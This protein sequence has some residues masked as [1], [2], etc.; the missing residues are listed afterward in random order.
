MSPTI[1]PSSSIPNTQP[2]SSQYAVDSDTNQVDID[3][4]KESED[5]SSHIS[6]LEHAP[7]R[8][9]LF[10]LFCTLLLSIGSHYSAHVLSS[11][12]S[13]LKEELN[14]SNAQYG[15]LQSGVSLVNTIIPVLGGRIIDIFGV[16]T[17]SLLS[18]F[19]ITF[20][21]LFVAMSAS[22]SSFPLMVLGR[23]LYGLGSGTIVTV[24]H[25]ILAHW[26]RGKWLSITIG[27]QIAVARLSSFLSIA[28][29]VP[30]KNVSGW[31][32]TPFYL[33]FLLCAFS[34]AI[35]VFYVFGM[36]RYH[37]E[38][39]GGRSD[40]VTEEEYKRLRRK[41]KF[42]IGDV[43]EFT[44]M[45]WVIAYLSFLMGGSWTVFLHIAPELMKLH[46]NQTE[47]LAAYNASVGQFLPIVVSP[48][49]GY[50]L[51]RHGH[52]PLI[53]F[54]ATTSLL[55]SFVLLGFAPLT[56]I[57]GLLLFSIS[58]TFGPVSMV[59][60]IPLIIKLSSVGTALGI[61]KSASNIATTMMDPLVGF[62]QDETK[63]YT[64]P[65]TLLTV[66]AVLAVTLSL[67]LIYIDKSHNKGLLSANSTDRSTLL[68][69]NQ[70][71]GESRALLEESTTSEQ[72]SNDGSNLDGNDRGTGTLETQ[73]LR[74]SITSSRSERN[75]LKA[76]EKTETKRINQVMLTFWGI[77]L[78]TSWIVFAGFYNRGA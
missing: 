62:L 60:S 11:L 56:P 4:D 5:I 72:L 12:K 73:S 40:I 3:S 70:D 50:M 17:G 38:Q 47:T 76:K 61:Y 64:A 36:K 43:M 37:R 51:D 49:L 1:R 58:L 28:T 42:N 9:K 13:T 63:S 68:S 2:N 8:W 66:M 21:E 15:V 33:S 48:F 46:F 27:I 34:L 31:Y 39:A 22:F 78:L 67:F 44:G 53:T 74:G 71:T 57:V 16:A 77:L 10:A 29:V 55:L 14:I 65:M 52:R 45:F 6:S 20:G 54:G 18:S 32:G 19:L 24:Q 25:T 35:N 7:V 75:I 26:F 23:A 41:Q 69:R 59:S 30:I